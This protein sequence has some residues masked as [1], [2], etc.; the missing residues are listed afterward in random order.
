MGYTQQGECRNTGRTH[1]K[2]GHKLCVG[3]VLSEKTKALI[4]KD[5]TARTKIQGGPMLGKKQTPEARKKISEAVKKQKNRGSNKGQHW[6]LERRNA[7]DERKRLGKK[8]KRFG[9]IRIITKYKPIK[10][11][12]GDYHPAWNEIRKVIYKR[13]GWTCQVCG[14]HCKGSVSKKTRSIITCH[15]IDYDKKNNDPLNLITLC[16]SCHMKT[17]FDR[18]DWINFLKTQ[19]GSK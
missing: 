18:L 1:L 7:Q 16:R 17:N 9:K 3:R 11:K 6:S 2:K 13:D 4:G 15:H 14:V 12:C 19:K 8:N 10:H 5:V